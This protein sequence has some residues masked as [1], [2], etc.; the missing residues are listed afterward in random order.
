MTRDTFLGGEGS[1]FFH[2]D[3]DGRSFYLPPNS[4]SNA[5][6]LTTLRYLLIQDWDLDD[7]GRPDTL[8][9]LYGAPGR[10]LQDGAR[11]TVERAPTMFGEVSFRVES[12]L[13]QGEVRIA[14]SPPNH[15]PRTLLVRAPLPTGWRVAAARVGQTVL[16]V[17]GDGA[18]DVT[19]QE[20]PFELRLEVERRR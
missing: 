9:L 3:K 7:D 2:G 17:A 1:R 14:V 19:G 15:R 8:R 11:I 10:W 20:Q 16:P 18:V 4:T 5:M 6:F 12:R 13:T